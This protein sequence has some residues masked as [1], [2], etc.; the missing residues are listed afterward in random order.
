M[1]IRLVEW[2]LVL[3]SRD[4]PSRIRAFAALCLCGAVVLSACGTDRDQPVDAV[5]GWF[6]A[7]V[8]LDLARAQALTCAANNRATDDALSASGGLSREIDLSNLRARIAV[9]LSGLQ[10][11][12]KS[13][14][15]GSA[16]VRVSGALNGRPVDQEI[17]LV[18]E[19]DAWKVCAQELPD[20]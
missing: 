16:I 5:R 18:K 3:G 7:I 14:G 10:F 12:E 13:A 11:E 15:D 8:A 19:D 6:E 4:I 1:L 9:D 17:R 20:Q 2:L